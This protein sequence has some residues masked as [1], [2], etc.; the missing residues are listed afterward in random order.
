MKDTR[1]IRLIKTFSKEELKSFGKFLESPFLKPSRNT[2][3]LYN[4]ITKFHP[5]F[6][7][8]KLDKKNVFKK[9]FPNESYDEKKI[10]NYIID[11]MRSAK[12]FLIHKSLDED[13]IECLLFL[14]NEY[15]NRKLLNTNLSLLVD[16]EKKLK[17]GF[18]TTS[19]YLS[20]FRKLIFLKSSYYTDEN[21]FDKSIECEMEYFIVSA[22]QFI[23]DYTQF[24]SSK[25]PAMN[26]HGIKM[27][28][29]FSDAIIKC[30]DI[31]KLI[32]LTEKEEFIN[33]FLISLHYYRL[34]TIEQP[35]NLNHYYTLKEHFIKV[36]SN[37][38][39]D[40][41]FFMFTYLQNYCVLKVHEG[42]EV[43]KREGFEIYKLMLEHNSYSYSENEY[44]EILTF[45]NI[46]HFCYML[47][48]IEWLKSFIDK[49]TNALNPEYRED[50]RNFS[51][52]NFYF[53]QKE[54]EKSL[55]FISRRF[56]H[57]IFLFKTDVK[58]LM[59]QIYYELDHIEQAFSLVDSYK[60]FLSSNKEISESLKKIY[61]KFLKYYFEL[62]KIKSGQSKETP[63]FIKSKIEKEK[64]L[65]NKKWLMQKSLELTTNSDS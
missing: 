52:A 15:Y 14:G 2:L 11:L 62:L 57:E 50:M 28:N 55:E 47:N 35:D 6:E 51:F 45:R 9:I 3:L 26:T 65:V 31:D 41:Q 21:E 18:T 61:T 30:F 32:K 17:P 5:D 19:D 36:I 22:T 13:E 4:Y 54:F 49:Y 23:I 40:E 27:A 46:I 29:N 16:I 60:H 1:L 63:S 33:S 59:I 20:K 25:K 24:L 64:N 58:N 48:E 34:K 39:R 56:N 10:A 37:L 12:D 43:F 7:T 53:H 42:N 38:N 8:D 44:M